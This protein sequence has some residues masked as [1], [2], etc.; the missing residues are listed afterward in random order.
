[1]EPFGAFAARATVRLRRA[2]VAAY[3]PE[4]GA[5]GA[6][7]AM[8]YGWQHS[9]RIG[10]MAN[11]AGY[12]YRVGQTAAR[13]HLRVGPPLPEPPIDELP[14]VEPRL[15]GLLNQLSEAQRTCVLLVH[16]YGWSQQDVA[17]LLDVSHS[18]V[19]T[20]LARA[21]AHLRATLEVDHAP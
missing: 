14:E 5:E 6:A 4:A 9:R 11:P 18:T 1:M 10:A 12:L 3:G 2:L 20:H 13:R 15:I 19:R 8:A 21:L 17:D 7:E 16:G